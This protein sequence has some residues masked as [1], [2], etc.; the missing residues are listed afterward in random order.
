MSAYASDPEPLSVGLAWPEGPA[1]LPGGAVAFVETYRSQVS[2]WSAGEGYRPLASVGGGPNAVALGDDGA[3]YACQNGGVVG[4][5]RARDRRPPSIQRI[6]ADGR[7]E[8]VATRVAGIEL[9]APNDLAFGADGR[10]YFTDPGR[11]DPEAR[12]DP[13]YVFALGADGS[14][15][16]VADLGPVYPN[17]IVVEAA[18]TLVWVESY[19]RAVKRRHRDGSI[20]TLAILDQGHVPDGLAVAADGD[21]YVA[22]VTSGGIDIVGAAGAARGFI[23]VGA[24]PTNCAFDGRR[25]YVTDGGIPGESTESNAVGTLW[26]L[27]LEVAG[28]ELFRGRVLPVG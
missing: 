28:Q 9:R 21:L 26:A 12:P 10:L 18:G 6:D 14:G 15:E 1:V 5:W 19:T 25:L 16:L 4:P 3:F 24:V 13:G 11:Y 2:T 17:G 20:E 8:V 22:T 7:V 27:E 23:S